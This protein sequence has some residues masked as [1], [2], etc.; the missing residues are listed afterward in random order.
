MLLQ[1]HKE[2]NAVKEATRQPPAWDHIYSLMRC[3][4]RAY[5]LGLHC[6][7]DSISKKHIKLTV[8]NLRGLMDY[9]D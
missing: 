3:S 1:R 4:S 2:I 5:E 8:Q 9:I 7:R 6:W